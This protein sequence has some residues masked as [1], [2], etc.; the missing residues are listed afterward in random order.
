MKQSSEKVIKPTIS[1]ILLDIEDIKCTYKLQLI[2]GERNGVGYSKIEK[3]LIRIV[4]PIDYS[5]L[6]LEHS[7]YGGTT[8]RTR[9]I[10]NTVKET[11]DRLS[12]YL[13][14][15]GFKK[16]NQIND[17]YSVDLYYENINK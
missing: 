2:K 14:Y 16:S 15:E 5:I 4:S 10:D 13:E 1:D 9:M 12:S 17:T 8:E 3:I 6:R 11:V 7:L